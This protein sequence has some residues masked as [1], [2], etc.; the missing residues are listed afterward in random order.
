MNDKETA[1]IF[2]TGVTVGVVY[3]LACYT[4]GYVGGRL[5]LNHV[6]TK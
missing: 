6:E 4:V 3:M 5:F 2:L 1:K